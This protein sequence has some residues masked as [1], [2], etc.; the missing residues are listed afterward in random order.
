MSNPKR[1]HYVPQLSLRYFT[2]NSGLFWV[3]DRDTKEYRQQNPVNTAIQCHYYTYRDENGDKNFNIE[4]G[5]AELE[6]MTKPIIDKIDVQDNITENEKVILANFISF[7][8]CR[9]PAFEKFT[10]ELRDKTLREEFKNLNSSKKQVESS[11]EK[12]EKETGKKADVTPEEI[13]DVVQNDKYDIVFHREQSI[14]SMLML[15][16]RLIDIILQIDWLFIKAPRDTSFIINDNPFLLL[17][18]KDY[19]STSLYDAGVGI[20]TP[21]AEKVFPLTSNTCLVMLDHGKR[22][23]KLDVDNKVVWEINCAIAANSDRFVISPDKLLLE[24]IVKKTK[25]DQWKIKERVS[26]GSV[27][28]T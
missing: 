10:N 23:M 7:Q 16:S 14:R 22:I 19:K 24:K 27:T 21:G 5:F 11:I 8:Y 6:G 18:P 25:I 12:Y 13:I 1:Q 20:I 28:N 17:P 3:F 2:D 26:V 9:V 4:N 15:G